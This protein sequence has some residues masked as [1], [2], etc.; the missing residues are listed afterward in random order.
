MKK[1][2]KSLIGVTGSTGYLGG[3]LVSA[4]RAQSLNVVE[5]RRSPPDAESGAL[6]RQLDLARPIESTS[7][8]GLSCLVHAAWDLVETDRRRAWTV[9]VEG[10]K[11]LLESA[12]AGGVERV[13]FVSSMSAYFGTKQDYGLMKLAVERAVL[14]AHQVVVRPGLV[15]GTQSGGMALTLEKL[16]RLP[17]IPVFRGAHQFTLHVDDF[18]AA[19]STLVSLKEVPSGVIGLANETPTAF[20]ELM[21]AL[22]AAAHRSPMT[23]EVPWRPLLGLLRTAEKIGVP[24]PV[25]SDSLLGLVRPASSVP[26]RELATEL[27]L[28]FRPFTLAVDSEV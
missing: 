21:L 22:A 23:V 1:A 13:I 20:R 18:L 3:A 14:E 17:I 26:G 28:T 8:E 2:A 9:N 10:S 25:R 4:L 19:V 7:F 24:L 12:L 11:R 27:G 15:Y 5:F 16:A 6:V